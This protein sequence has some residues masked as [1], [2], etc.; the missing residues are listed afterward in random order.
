MKVDADV[1]AGI[2]GALQIDGL[3]ALNDHA[4]AVGGGQLQ[5]AIVAGDAA[6][7]GASQNVG[8]FGV[9]V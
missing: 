8:T 1:F 2:G 6:V 3:L 9:G 5:S 7:N 4:V